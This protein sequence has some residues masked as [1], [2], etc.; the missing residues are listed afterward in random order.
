MRDYYAVLGLAQECSQDDVKKAYRRLARKYHPDVYS[1]SDA[2]QRFEEITE[3]Y[4]ILSD[5]VK[6]RALDRK[7]RE[8]RRK[9]GDEFEEMRYP[10]KFHKAGTSTVWVHRDREEEIYER[11]NE[12]SRIWY[13]RFVY[14]RP[15]YTESARKS[16]AERYSRIPKYERTRFTVRDKPRY[17]PSGRPAYAAYDSFHK[18]TYGATGHSGIVKRSYAYMDMDGIAF[19]E[20]CEEDLAD[21]VIDVFSNKMVLALIVVLL[22]FFSIIS[23]IVYLIL[24]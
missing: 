15:R 18:P 14:Q 10:P 21:H 20:S 19:E 8:E 5:P 12:L 17:R 13:D 16:Y 6:R 24:L 1:G 2:A 22:T 23:F 9:H 3:A 7:L 4:R 11:F